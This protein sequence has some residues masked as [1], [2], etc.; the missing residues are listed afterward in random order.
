MRLIEQSA[1]GCSF[2]LITDVPRIRGTS[3]TIK[4]VPST[5][6][7]ASAEAGRQSVLTRGRNNVE[8][9]EEFAA[10]ILVNRKN[11]VFIC[12][13]TSVVMPVDEIDLVQ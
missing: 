8:E 3:V 12:R 5:K 9:V 1:S 6:R 10:D 7:P 11:E 4:S 13:A 2:F